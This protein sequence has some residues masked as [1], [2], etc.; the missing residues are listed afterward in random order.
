MEF[1]TLYGRLPSGTTEEKRQLWA[2]H[3]QLHVLTTDLLRQY[4]YH[5]G[6]AVRVV[7]HDPRGAPAG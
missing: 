3:A 7:H 6:E 4:A 2:I 1:H 5:G